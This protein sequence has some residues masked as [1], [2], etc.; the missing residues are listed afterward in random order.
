[1]PHTPAQICLI[2]QGL[3][4]LAKDDGDRAAEVNGKGFSKMDV[5]I[6]HSL[7]KCR[8][9][10]EKQAV[11]GAKLIK[12]YRRQLPVEIVGACAIIAGE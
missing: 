1:M 10:T 7:A 5:G 9:L 2:L 3:R 4:L 12:K 11:V 8:T 6:G